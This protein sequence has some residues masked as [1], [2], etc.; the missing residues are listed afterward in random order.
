M[1][2]IVNWYEFVDMSV[3]AERLKLLR[4][5]RNITQ[6]RLAELLDVSPRVYNRWEKGGNIP[7][8]ETIV[9]IADILKISLDEL[10][11]R[12]EPS[13]DVAIQNSELHSLC[14]KLDILSDQDQ[15]AL[16]VMIDSLVK[17]AEMDRIWKGNR[18][19]P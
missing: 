19:M 2:D 9:R 14:G 8:F 1:A 12:K 4:Q 13:T 18:P 11:G 5:S 10:A 16:I 3:F 15:Q 6:T 7:H 17:K